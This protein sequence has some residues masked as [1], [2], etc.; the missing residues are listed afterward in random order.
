MKCTEGVTRA[1][2]LAAWLMAGG[3]AFKY[4]LEDAVYLETHSRCGDTLL[5]L[6]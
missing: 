1:V 4:T 6:P 5:P 3:E 2:L